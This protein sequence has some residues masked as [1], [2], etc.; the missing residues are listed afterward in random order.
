MSVLAVL[1]LIAALS[2]P[3]EARKK[4]EPTPRLTFPLS[5][6]NH[7]AQ[8]QPISC[9]DTLITSF[10]ILD[11]ADKRLDNLDILVRDGKIVAV[12]QNLDRT[13]RTPLSTGAASGSRPASSTLQ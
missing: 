11:G 2:F 10:T 12:S 7:P 9:T 4:K 1:A 3:A 8:H 5:A 6:A 13:I